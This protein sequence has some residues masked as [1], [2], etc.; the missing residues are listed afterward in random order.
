MKKRKP[1]TTFSFFI[2]ALLL[3]SISSIQAR[4][5]GDL[6]PD[7][8]GCSML[9]LH[10]TNE[11]KQINKI[12]KKLKKRNKYLKEYNYELDELYDDIQNCPNCS[13]RDSWITQYQSK[14][15]YYNKSIDAYNKSRDNLLELY[16]DFKSDSKMFNK[17]CV[18]KK[19]TKKEIRKFC[20][21][22]YNPQKYKLCHYDK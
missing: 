20:K 10:I 14:E 6:Y 18:S 22:V 19:L 1:F 11:D 2:F 15:R 12:N 16:D 7:I 3:I 21:S 4:P 8:K 5:F 9:Q 13:N 17:Y